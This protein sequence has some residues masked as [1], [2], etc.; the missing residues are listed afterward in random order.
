[1]HPYADSIAAICV[2]SAWSDGQITDMEK[3]A[4]DRILV[5][6]GFARPEV[7][8]RIGEALEKGPS[9]ESIYVPEDR[10]SQKE[11]MQYALTVCLADGQLNPPTIKF[12]AELANFLS[13]PKGLLEELKQQSEQLLAPKERAAPQTLPSRLDAL[14]PPERIAF[15]ETEDKL[16][17]ATRDMSQKTLIKKPL[18]Q[19]LYKGEEY[20]EEISFS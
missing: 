12:L 2:A 1:M 10:Q 16:P 5:R 20:G 7:M 17:P 14:L 6:L 11:Y 9:G 13:I 4:L 19:L 18:S 3:Q 15:E 8:R